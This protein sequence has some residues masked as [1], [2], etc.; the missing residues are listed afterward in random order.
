MTT[1]AP[2]SDRLAVVRIIKA[3]PRL[4]FSTLTGLLTASLLPA[5]LSLLLVTRM[6]I[7]WNVGACL[8]L[9]LAARMMFW[10]SHE[11]MRKR[12]LAQDEGRFIVM[13]LVV[14]AAIVSLGAI[15][16]ELAV[17][18]DL[19]GS[20]RY[21]HITLTVLT[22]VTSWAFTQLMFAM[23]YAHDYYVTE[24]RS[25]SGGL[26]FP[27]GQAPDYG[28]FLYFACVIGTSGQTADVSF[29]S[30]SMRRTGLVH[31]V[32]AFFFNTTL[33]ALSINIASGLF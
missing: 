33:L 14:I 9:A 19:H 12:A 31:C 6:I 21:T 5:S 30:R 2:I 4:F 32:L 27:G 26:E 28:D 10:S 3:R 20:L 7:G 1:T 16:A 17:V 15:F 29:S 18:K 13:M 24:A 11:K 22:I 25:G 8:Y 23:H